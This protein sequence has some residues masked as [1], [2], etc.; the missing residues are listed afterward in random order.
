LLRVDRILSNRGIGSRKEMNEL[1]KKSKVAVQDKETGVLTRIKGPSER[2][3]KGSTIF[4]NGEEIQPLPLILAYY[5]PKGMLSAMKDDK[6]GRSHLGEVLNERYIK[7]GLH[8]VGRLD[9]DTSGLILFSSSGD[10]TQRLLHPRHHIEKEYVATVENP[11]D[12]TSLAKRLEEGVQTTEGIHSAQLLDIIPGVDV[13]FLD[14]D[15]DQTRITEKTTP[16][17]VEVTATA[18]PDEIGNTNKVFTNVRLVVSEGKHRMVRRMLANLGHPVIELK[19]ER[20]GVITLGDMDV[21]EFR[22]LSVEELKWAEGLLL[23]S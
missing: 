3:P 5:K 12:E 10:L 9:Y 13:P 2:V 1:I 20:H 23:K 21:G 17:E 8:P 19:R 16:A 6:M 15:D 7:A 11:V 18:S 14:N 22:A 4:V